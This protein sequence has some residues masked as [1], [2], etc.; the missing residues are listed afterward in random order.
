M[1]PFLSPEYKSLPAYKVKF[2][3]DFTE[4]QWA[5]CLGCNEYIQEEEEVI[6]DPFQTPTRIVVSYWHSK[7]WE[8]SSGV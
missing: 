4:G 7:C 5:S 1:D 6:A 3:F 2:D 8:E